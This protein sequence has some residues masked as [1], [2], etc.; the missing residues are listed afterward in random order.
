MALPP[1]SHTVCCSFTGWIPDWRI[2][3]TH[4]LVQSRFGTRTK[5]LR[6]TPSLSLLAH[7]LIK[8]APH[9]SIVSTGDTKVPLVYWEAKSNVYKA[10]PTY[11]HRFNKDT[12]VQLVLGIVHYR[13]DTLMWW[14]DGQERV[15][16]VMQLSGLAHIS[17]WLTDLFS[18]VG[19]PHWP[20][21]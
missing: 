3:T 5:W 6:W 4:Q 18:S 2:A 21:A 15:H 14:M 8:Y 7:A 19:N 11:L 10:W 12:K 16:Y 20:V 13:M 17:P 9:T 1:S